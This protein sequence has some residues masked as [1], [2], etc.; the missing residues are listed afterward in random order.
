MP[1]IYNEVKRKAYSVYSLVCDLH[2][3][4]DD[5][6][7]LTGVKVNTYSDLRTLF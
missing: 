5:N 7:T 6:S 2:W 3:R 4:H 1:N